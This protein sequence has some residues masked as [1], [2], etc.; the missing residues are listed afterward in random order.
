MAKDQDEALRRLDEA[1]REDESENE[2]E[3]PDAEDRKDE[4]LLEEETL[5]QLLADEVPA[6]GGMI[7][8][9]YSN[10]YG[11]GLRNYASGYRAYNTDTCDTDLEQYSEQVRKE[12][13]RSGGLVAL[14]CLLA[15]GI[16]AVLLWWLLRYRGLL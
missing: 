13:K 16:I 9:N 7:Y 3:I 11:K 1:L 14:A 6:R 2:D 4:N 12:D 10:G 8:R 5:D 15:A